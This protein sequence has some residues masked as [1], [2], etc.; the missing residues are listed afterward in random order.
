MSYIYENN[1][2]KNFQGIT[3]YETIINVKKAVKHALEK[4]R[5]PDFN[6]VMLHNDISTLNKNVRNSKLMS[7]LMMYNVK[8]TNAE[9]QKV[10]ALKENVL[11]KRA[12]Q[13]N[14]FVHRQSN[15]YNIL[16]KKILNGHN[17]SMCL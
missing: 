15:V 12:I 10:E 16:K 3:L 6:Y 7:T 2:Q 11:S 8:P 5:K 14:P 9:N 17:K 4:H 13:S 1:Y